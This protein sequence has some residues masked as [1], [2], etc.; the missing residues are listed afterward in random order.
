[1]SI[2]SGKA[3]T[4]VFCGQLAIAQGLCAKHYKQ[5]QRHGAPSKEVSA[6]L[7]D[8]KKFKDHPLYTTWRS[9]TRTALGA[10][11]CED[12]KDF[13]KFVEDVGPK[14]EGAHSLK[15]LDSKLLFSKMNVRWEIPNTS[16][17][18]RADH[19]LRMKVFYEANPGYAGWASM[20]SK[21]GLTKEQYLEL[22]SQQNG[23][24]AICKKPEKRTTK[25][26]ELMKLHVDHCHN[27]KQIRGLLCHSCNTAIGHF[28][29][30]IDALKAAV[31][32]LGG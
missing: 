29:D 19:V 24:C 11:V 32:Y 12:W 17:A 25:S 4:V 31:E 14:P 13:E 10:L 1:M 18:Q 22:L 8:G 20:K 30:N 23:V 15:R 5:K 16:S 21:Y 9:M 28:E 27:T 26:G 3:C 7:I 2:P 6:K